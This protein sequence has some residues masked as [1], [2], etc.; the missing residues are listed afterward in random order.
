MRTFPGIITTQNELS[1]RSHPTTRLVVTG[2]RGPAQKCFEMI[3]SIYETAKKRGDRFIE[4]V[5]AK[6]DPPAGV[7]GCEVGTS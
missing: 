2:G 5:N 1:T 7:A 6:F 3:L 4:T